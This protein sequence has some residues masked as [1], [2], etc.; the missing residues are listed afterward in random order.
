MAWEMSTLDRQQ[1]PCVLRIRAPNSSRGV[2]GMS[3]INSAAPENQRVICFTVYPNVFW[4]NHFDKIKILRSQFD[5]TKK[6][7]KINF[8]NLY[9]FS[10]CQMK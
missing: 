6:F 1:G 7:Y 5:K 2:G 10:I 9:I 4:Q 3:P 8:A